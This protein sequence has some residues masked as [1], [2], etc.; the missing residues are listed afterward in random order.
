MP[1]QGNLK[2]TF[3]LD[4]SE[5]LAG[6]VDLRGGNL[7]QELDRIG[8]AQ[9]LQQPVISPAILQRP[10]LGLS[11][12]PV[13][14]AFAQKPVVLR[15]TALLQEVRQSKSQSCVQQ[16]AVPGMFVQLRQSRLLLVVI[17]LHTWLLYG[18]AS[19]VS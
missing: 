7:Q 18:T 13:T 5:A 10:R 3:V 2:N 11:F 12:I 17:A 9:R 4:N 14:Y 19:F 6:A 15:S 1:V 16:D 8:F